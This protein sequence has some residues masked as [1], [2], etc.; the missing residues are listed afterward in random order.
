MMHPSIWDKEQN[1]NCCR[2]TRY[3]SKT[4]MHTFSHWLLKYS[5]KRTETALIITFYL[6]Y[7]IICWDETWRIVWVLAWIAFSLKPKYLILLC[8]SKGEMKFSFRSGVTIHLLLFWENFLLRQMS[9]IF[10]FEIFFILY[11]EVLLFGMDKNIVGKTL[12]GPSDVANGPNYNRH[13]TINCSIF[14]V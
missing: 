3:L 10:I 6:I 9:Y 13:E 1:T 7:R 5:Q 14:Y 4:D 8:F 12:V 11:F 2:N